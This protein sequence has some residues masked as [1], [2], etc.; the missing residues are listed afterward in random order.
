MTVIDQKVIRDRAERLFTFLKEYVALRTK[1]TRDLLNYDTVLWLHAFPPESM[2]ESSSGAA[3]GEPEQTVWVTFRKP[4]FEKP[5][6]PAEILDPWIDERLLA[7][8]SQDQPKTNERMPH[9]YNVGGIYMDRPLPTRRL[10]EVP[11]LN[12]FW[13]E[14]VETAWGW[15]P[16]GEKDRESR[17]LK[18]IY[19]ALYS[20]FQKQQRLGEAYEIVLGVLEV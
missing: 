12:G 3:I 4:T 20:L 5:P 11:E 6:K 17:R 19:T 7:D 8:S 16:W 14:Y 9:S 2:V 15:G 10:E 13:R 18:E 1:V